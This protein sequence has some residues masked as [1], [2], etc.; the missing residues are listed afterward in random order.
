MNRSKNLG[1]SKACP[2]CKRTLFRDL[3][4]DG[5]GS[6]VLKCPNQ[7]CLEKVPVILVKKTVVKLQ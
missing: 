3:L 7:Q 5:E 2:Y 6:I 4:I 1:I